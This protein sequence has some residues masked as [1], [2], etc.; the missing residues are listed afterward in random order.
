M[1]RPTVPAP[2]PSAV[3]R[4]T[5]KRTKSNSK[6]RSQWDKG[7]IGGYLDGLSGGRGGALCRPDRD[8][9]DLPPQSP[10]DRRRFA[11]FSQ[12]RDPGQR[13]PEKDSS[14]AAPRLEGYG[15]DPAR[16]PL[17]PLLLDSSLHPAR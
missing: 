12:D 5:S 8:P 11:S 14:L 3:G 15:P 2:S 7:R 13:P 9:P 1:T 6:K 16:S 4:I 10:Q 17:P